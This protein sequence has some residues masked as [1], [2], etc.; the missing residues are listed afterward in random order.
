[1]LLATCAALLAS[2]CDRDD[3]QIKVY[4]VSKAPLEST[5]P[6]VESNMPG[7][8]SMPTNTSTPSVDAMAPPQSADK[9]QIKWDVPAEWTSVPPSAMRYA[10]FATEKNGEKADISVVTFPGE[11][12]SDADNVNRWRGQIGLAPLQS[13]DSVV[14][15]LNAG[16]VQF[17]TLDMAG[18]N[19]RMLAAWTRR[20]GRSWFFKLT[21]PPNLVEQEKPKFTA[22]LQSVRF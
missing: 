6:P 13:I 5:P 17:S 3:Q 10:S 21:G 15:P 9:P 18:T 16:G 4:R 2:A 14:V 11:G 1:M 8:T 22:F 19:S 7:N 12:G 20:D